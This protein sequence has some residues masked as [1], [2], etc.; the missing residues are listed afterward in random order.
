MV[1]LLCAPDAGCC[2]VLN[3]CYSTSVPPGDVDRALALDAE[4]MVA[5]LL[6]LPEDQWFDRKSGRVRAKDL[7]ITIVALSNADGGTI[8]IGLH[9]GQV[10]GVSAARLNELRQAALDFT[11]PP[12][13][14][15]F[16]QMD[17]PKGGS[18]TAL[19][20]AHVEPGDQI[21]T[22]ADGTCYLR[23]GDESRK[24]TH[25][26]QR[27]LMYDRGGA[28]YD[29]TPVDLGVSDLDQVQLQ[30]YTETIGASDVAGMLRARDLV[31]RRDRVTAAACLLFDGRPQREFP[32]AYVRVIRY[33]HAERGTGAGMSLE[34][35]PRP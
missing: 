33:G 18:S 2:N 1:P 7:A 30:A 31:D 13:R 17:V 25:A 8:V 23:V 11:V 15:R 12:V 32:S 21:T 19:L 16:S 10:E 5:T 29:S 6:A 22:T 14:A 26:Q 4:S 34:E 3:K 24:L 20:V 28:P 35:R 9:A 27:E